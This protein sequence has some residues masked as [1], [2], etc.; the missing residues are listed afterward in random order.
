MSY[1]EDNKKLN[2]EEK[3]SISVE[4]IVKM[5]QDRH[6][7][8][9]S[10]PEKSISNIKSMSYNTQCS[11]SPT[12]TFNNSSPLM[13]TYG[14]VQKG[15]VWA[16]RFYGDF[17]CLDFVQFN[18]IR[19]NNVY[20]YVEIRK[21]S[22]GLPMGVPAANDSGLVYRTPS[23]PYS[24]IPTSWGW[25]YPTI[26]TILP[27]T[28]Y[29]WI[30][31][32]PVDFSDSPIY[33]DDPTDDRFG[34]QD[35][36]NIADK[37]SAVFK[38]GAWTESSTFAFAVFKLPTFATPSN[39]QV[40]NMCWGPGLGSQCSIPPERPVV[41]TGTTVTIKA[42]IANS[43]GAGQ[44]RAVFKINGS[45][46]SDQNTPSLGTYPGGGFW[47]P[48][49]TY[50][51]SSSSVTLTVD[52]YGWD[53][54][55][56]T[57]TNTQSA[58]ISATTPT[59]T[60]I[61]IDASTLVANVGDN[62]TLTAYGVTPT[63]QPFT[64]NFLDRSNNVLGTCTTSNGM[65]SSVWNT[66]GLAQ[67]TYYVRATVTG[68]CTSTE[69]AI[70]LS[71]PIRQWSVD[72]TVLDNVTSNPI[73]TAS[74]T[75]GVRTLQT[76]TNGHVLFTGVDEGTINVSI[77]KTGYNNSPTNPESLYSNI[78]RTYRLVPVSQNPGSLRFMTSP[79]GIQNAEVHFIGDVPTLKGVTDVN[80]I[81]SIG[82]LT[83]GRVVNYEV[84]K[85]G[86]N[87][88]T[89]SATVVGNTTTDVLVTM[90]PVST[91]GSVCIHSNPAGA[92]I[93]IDTVA[94]AGKST[95]L[96][97]GGCVAVNTINNLAAGS[98]NYELTLTGYQNKT[99]TFSITVGQTTD[100][101]AGALTPL[102]TLGTLNMASNPAGA[103]IYIKTGG[104][105][106]DTGYVT[107]TL[108]T[109]TVI[110]TLTAGTYEYKLI[111]T[112]YDDY[113]NTFVIT[114][115]QIT[116]VYAVLTPVSP[117]TGTLSIS[118]F[119]Q[120][121]AIYIMPEGGAWQDTTRI[122]GPVGSPT[123]VTGLSPGN[124]SYKL[125]Y[126]I[127]EDKI[128]PFVATTGQTTSIHIDL[129]P[130]SSTTGTL[131]ISSNPEGAKIYIMPEG[132][133]WQDISRVTGPEGN[134]ALITG[135][136]PGEYLYKLTLTGYSDN[137]SIFTITAGQTT[138][139]VHVD[140]VV[141]QQAGGGGAIMMAAAAVIAAA[142]F[143]TKKPSM[144][145]SSS[146]GHKTVEELR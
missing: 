15:K 109:P 142:M 100:H 55:S 104:T 94:Q 137:I 127:Y 66:T 103:R 48:T 129:T 38:A 77:T 6:I 33:R 51:M 99:G 89:G 134:P 44:V 145:K 31:F 76:D 98:H 110:T 139:P 45:T 126:P 54:S 135:L 102:P 111:L 119:P 30:C 140:L 49:T 122:T 18:M 92:S 107:G 136:T 37:R 108:G 10:I 11:G 144:K 19:F 28:A 131:S 87:T 143:M 133:V 17:K 8:D 83:A 52:G 3:R 86:Y 128:G 32:V 56:W 88:A 116:D 65:C 7:L 21:D 57:L 62:I 34:L 115:G 120:G 41:T 96:S 73:P 71:L 69:L 90:T 22:A 12:I 93:K 43:G 47:S 26:G 9:M 113:L 67:G 130:S 63:T 80:G 42:D 64:V 81:L 39:A 97:G 105:Y 72:I 123:L 60:G 40:F 114:A 124:Y 1:D 118:S 138:G 4:D 91:T 50:L 106:Q 146:P 84:R 117:T 141:V 14:A 61:S 13:G 101:N 70:G 78:T 36:T 82:N 27:T 59:C 29:Y 25:V 85:T 121:A 35:G 132:G 58:T 74:V 23:I 53:G 16:Q 68:Q 79:P 46:I 75:I 112:G 2:L 95:A 5:Y 125:T 24:D 20:F